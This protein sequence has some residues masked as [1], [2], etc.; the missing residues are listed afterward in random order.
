MDPN[1]LTRRWRTPGLVRGRS[2]H[3]PAPKARLGRLFPDEPSGRINRTVHHT[4]TYKTPASR[5]QL[6]HRSSTTGSVPQRQ[7]ATALFRQTTC[8][9][10]RYS[11]KVGVTASL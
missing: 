9:P 2:G 11:V 3:S 1:R 4:A 10:A 8:P 6:V 7:P 5:V